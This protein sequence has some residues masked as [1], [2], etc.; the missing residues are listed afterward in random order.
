MFS[1]IP[2]AGYQYAKEGCYICPNAGPLIDTG[3]QIEG[4]GIMALCFT[5]L[6]DMA[7]VAGFTDPDA[8]TEIEQLAQL[9][10]RQ[11]KDLTFQKDLEGNLRK[12]LRDAHRERDVARE[13]LAESGTLEG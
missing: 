10:E 8:D 9:V 4:E 3:V 7:R 5:C 2:A 11:A 1:K 12:Q 13:A 6:A